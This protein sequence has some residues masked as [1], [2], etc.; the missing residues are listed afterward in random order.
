[1]PRAYPA[2]TPW[3][4]R[5]AP[6]ERAIAWPGATRPTPLPALVAVTAI[7]GFTFV[8]VQGPVGGLPA[9][10]VPRRSLRDLDGSCSHRSPGGSLRTL[11]RGGCARPASWPALLSRSPTALQ[12]AGPR[13][14]RRSRA[15]AS[16]PA[17]TSS[18]RRF[19]RSPASGHRSPASVWV[20]VAL[21]LAGLLLLERRAG[22]LG[23]RERARARERGRPVLPDRR[24]G[25]VRAALRRACAHASCRWRSR[26]R[27]SSAIAVAPG[28]LEAPPADA[29][30]ERCS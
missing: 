30:W 6:P 26:A 9:L 5:A 20:G 4:R 7:W 19:S 13:A 15:R 18:S 28:Q 17:S 3:P 21:A 2:G 11:P 8:Q 29:S 27:D 16:S 23:A 1:M 10:R 24:D 25:A 14:A 12:T 22:R